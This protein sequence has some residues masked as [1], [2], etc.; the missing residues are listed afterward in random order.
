MPCKFP[1]WPEPQHPFLHIQLFPSFPSQALHLNLFFYVY[2]SHFSSYSMMYLYVSWWWSLNPALFFLSIY[3]L[4]SILICLLKNSYMHVVC[5]NHIHLPLPPLLC[6][7]LPWYN[8]PLPS[9]MSFTLTTYWYQLVV[10]YVYGYG[11]ILRV[12]ANNQWPHP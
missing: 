12:W 2:G 8:Q 4:D 1:Q 7:R 5:L 10:P 11:A 9:S 3:F 6:L